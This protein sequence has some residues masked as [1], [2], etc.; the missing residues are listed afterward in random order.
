MNL[1]KKPVRKNITLVGEKQISDKDSFTELKLSPFETK[2]LNHDAHASKAKV[3]I[4]TCLSLPD[5]SN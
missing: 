3:D 4:I 5:L 2:I 1:K